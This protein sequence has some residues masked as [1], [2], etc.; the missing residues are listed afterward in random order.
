MK[1]LQMALILFF[2]I[3]GIGCS[4]TSKGIK[5][6]DLAVDA[7]LV[8]PQLPSTPPLA[9]PAEPQK[10]FDQEVSSATNP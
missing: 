4:Q 9:E 7:E 1:I 5:N 6:Q 2:T 10:G 8:K 3:T